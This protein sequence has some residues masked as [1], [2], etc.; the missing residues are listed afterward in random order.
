MAMRSLASD[1]RCGRGGE[2]LR[3]DARPNINR[4]QQRIGALRRPA[5]R[6]STSRSVVQCRRRSVRFHSRAERFGKSTILSLVAGLRLQRHQG[7]VL[8]GSVPIG[9]P[10]TSV[11]MVFQ[12]PVLLEWRTALGNVMLS[13]QSHHME[14]AAA[15]QR[16]RHLLASVG[17]EGFEQAYP[18][19][20][21]G[22]MQQRASICRALIHEPDTLLMDEPF[23]AL[24]AITRDQIS[25]DLGNMLQERSASVLFVTHSVPEAVFLSDQIV[26]MTGRPGQISRIIDIEVPRPRNLHL[27]QS[28][29]FGAY[30]R[31]NPRIVYGRWPAARQELEGTVRQRPTRCRI[32]G[33][34]E[35]IGAR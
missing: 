7:Q 15:E 26:V 1:P 18:A 29:K 10:V 11:G 22:G 3:D 20:L 9:G 17:L 21:S 28:P 32:A 12:K 14:W 6:R 33:P 23:A 19:E 8:R 5:R 25:V 31:G 13:A 30:V 24:D 4:A 27:R 2:V 35:L 16:A 34:A